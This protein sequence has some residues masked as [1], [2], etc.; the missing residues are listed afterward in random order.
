LNDVP[1]PEM[2]D[3]ERGYVIRSILCKINSLGCQI[4]ITESLEGIE[5][6]LA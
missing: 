6:E 5:L 1:L 2:N 3:D 4:S